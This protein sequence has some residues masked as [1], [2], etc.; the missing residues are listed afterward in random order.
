MIDIYSICKY[1]WNVA[2][3]KWKVCYGKIEIIFLAVEQG[4]TLIDD[5]SV[6]DL[7]VMKYSQCKK[8]IRP[9]KVNFLV[10]RH[11]RMWKF[12]AAL[13]ILLQK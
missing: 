8:C 1:N 3:Y 9:Y 13:P 10:L 11:A 7:M 2:T 12:V 5:M 6:V 4:R